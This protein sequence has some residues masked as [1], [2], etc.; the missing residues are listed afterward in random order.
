VLYTLASVVDDVEMGV[1]DVVRGADH[2]TNT[3]VQVQIMAALGAGA[4][5]FAHHS[6]LTGPGG[7]ALSK[8]LGALSLAELREQGVEPMA[9]L[10]LMA[11]LGTADAVEPRV[12]HAELVAGFD[13]ARFGAAPVRFDAEELRA[14]SAKVLHRLD[15]PAV[16][17]DLAALGVDRPEAFWEAVRENV[18]TRREIAEWWAIARDGAV[19]VV[20]GE[21]RDFVAEAA[22]MLP[23]PPWDE[24]T[25]GAWTAAVKAATGRKGGALFRP[26]RRWLT[27]RD[28]GPDMGRL[29]PF[30][31][32][33]G[34]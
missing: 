17:G 6:L 22:A 7:E 32:L 8:R 9:L 5:R 10:S 25:W 28:S 33:P 34:E 21:D 14:L 13:L 15:Y 29:M 12:T 23:P 27:G 20:A 16:A 26:L 3:A 11:R 4:P 18:A 1:T 2:V 19:P 31:Q 30:L 24:A